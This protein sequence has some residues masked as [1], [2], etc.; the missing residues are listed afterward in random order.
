MESLTPQETR[1]L[2]MVAQGLTNK[3]IAVKLD[4]S[5]ST[6]NQY[7]ARITEKLGISGRVKLALWAKE[8]GLVPGEGSV[9]QTARALLS[10]GDFSARERAELALMIL[11]P[12][13]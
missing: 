13:G 11:R 12:E 10:T 2:T 4:V 1:V 9:Y 5:L 8:A 7:L 3:E 6:A